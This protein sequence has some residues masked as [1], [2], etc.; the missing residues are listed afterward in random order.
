MLDALRIRPATPADRADLR[1]AIMELQDYERHLHDSRLAGELVADRYLDWM[2]RRSESDGIILVAESDG[3]FAGFVA[4]WVEH[5]ANAGETAEAN[6]F[7][8]ISDVCVMPA[9][10]GRRLATRLLGAIEHYLRRAG[11]VRL[12]IAAL[13][14][15]RSAR[16]SYQ[17]AGF[18]PYEIIH[19][20]LIGT[21]KDG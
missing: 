12:R 18:V 1:R 10:R 21:G 16:Q 14:A 19:E 6:R 7:G 20:K 4:G 5:A 13:A 15:N 11:V 17:H 9:Y 3:A 2:Q 8:L